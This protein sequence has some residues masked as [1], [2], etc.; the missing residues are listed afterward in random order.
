MAAGLPKRERFLNG[1]KPS[2]LFHNLDLPP[3]QNHRDFAARTAGPE[4]LRPQ[5][6]KYIF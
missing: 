3:G 1:V 2:L 5:L 4:A 6:G